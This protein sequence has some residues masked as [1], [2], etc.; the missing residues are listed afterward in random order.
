MF[1]FIVNPKMVQF[2][3]I[4]HHIY[5]PAVDGKKGVSD[6]EKGYGKDTNSVRDR[7]AVRADSSLVCS[8]A[9]R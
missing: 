4:D 1:G 9:G 3:L 7:V 6:D 2:P 8:A 5:A